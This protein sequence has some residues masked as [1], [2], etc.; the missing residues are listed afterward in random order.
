MC[1]WGTS[2]TNIAKPKGPGLRT[3]YCITAKSI[4]HC[5]LSIYHSGRK[6]ATLF[7]SKLG[8]RSYKNYVQW[9]ACFV[10]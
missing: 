6:S 3:T 9:D 2:L 4:Y 10:A 5:R 1:P 8:Y 7:N